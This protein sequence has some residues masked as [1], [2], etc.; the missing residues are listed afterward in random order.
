[1]GN[2]RYRYIGN[3]INIYFKILLFEGS[4]RVLIL[5]DIFFDCMNFNEEGLV[6]KKYLLNLF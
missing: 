3:I 2:F 1:M 6:V 5:V 4:Y